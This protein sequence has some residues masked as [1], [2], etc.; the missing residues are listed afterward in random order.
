MWSTQYPGFRYF[1]GAYPCFFSFSIP[2]SSVYS[3][4]VM[5]GEKDVQLVREVCGLATLD[6]AF[7]S[8]VKHSSVLL[9]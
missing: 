4:S 6:H 9:M 7:Q 8:P 3:S 5:R 1:V 2:V